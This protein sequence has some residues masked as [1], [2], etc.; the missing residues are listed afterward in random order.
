MARKRGSSWQGSFKA[1]DKYHRYSFPTK[2]QAEEWERQAREGYAETGTVTPPGGRSKMTLMD[3]F[4]AYKEVVWNDHHR[5]Q[6]RSE[7][8]LMV[9]ALPTDDPDKIT[10]AHLL[11]ALAVWKRKGYKP[12]TI[13]GRFSRLSKLLRYCKKIGEVEVTLEFPRVPLTSDQVRHR[14]LTEEEEKA[15]I[16]LFDHWG[17]TAYARVTEVLIDTGCR[18]GEIMDSEAHNEPVRWSEITKGAGGTLAPVLDRK[19]GQMR[20]LIHL[21]RTKSDTPRTLPLTDRAVEALLWSKANGDK[22]P[23]DCVNRYQYWW[24]F[25]KVVAHLGLED[26]VPYTLRHTCAS[27]LVQRGA[28]LRRVKDWMGHASINMTLKYAKLT[29]TDIFELGDLL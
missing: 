8:T 7:F 15:L 2:A 27:R 29:P 9:E 5:A 4:E 23:F 26:V 28:D 12:T 19:T 22:R 18:P 1:P 17:L 11:Q 25:R 6:C 24:H 13:N 3:L 10:E 14:F 20:E 21:M 16:G